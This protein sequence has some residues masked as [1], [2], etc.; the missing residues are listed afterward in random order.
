MEGYMLDFRDARSAD[1]ITI[2]THQNSVKLC[3]VA[4][5]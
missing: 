3:Y 4:V 1:L 5:G 2:G